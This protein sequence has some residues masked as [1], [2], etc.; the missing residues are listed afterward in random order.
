M[1]D[2]FL[3]LLKEL[4]DSLVDQTKTKPQET[5]DLIMI[6]QKEI[7]SFNPPTNMAEEGKWLLAITSI[8]TTNSIVNINHE[9]NL[10]STT[11]PGHWNSKTAGTTI[12]E[13]K[14]N[15]PQI[16]KWYWITCRTS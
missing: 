4:T 1:S 14:I 10:F 3:L 2:E 13:K 9:K 12:D 15:I 16:S 5:L 8:E 11:L 6:K 7:F